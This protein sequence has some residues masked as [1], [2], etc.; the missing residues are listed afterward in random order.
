MCSV[1]LYNLDRT[2][3]ERFKASCFILTHRTF[4]SCVKHAVTEATVEAR[5]SVSV[6][7]G[8]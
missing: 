4:A 7:L 1:G 6:L 3:K 8:Q 5:G 2:A